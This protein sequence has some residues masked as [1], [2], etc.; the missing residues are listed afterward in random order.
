MTDGLFLYASRALACLPGPRDCIMTEDEVIMQ[1]K[2]RTGAKILI[3]R[4]RKK[5]DA[6]GTC[7]CSRLAQ[8]SAVDS[9][10]VRLY[11]RRKTL[12]RNHPRRRDVPYNVIN[13]HYICIS[14][15][16]TSASEHDVF[17][18]LR[19]RALRIVTAEVGLAHM[20]LE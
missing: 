20:L 2:E 9:M 4:G 3:R 15:S 19:D 1:H 10:C 12:Q 18:A 14:S 11:H 17:Q 13:R 6:G 5:K 7:E 16:Q 8:S